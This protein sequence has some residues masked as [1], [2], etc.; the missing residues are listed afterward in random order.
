MTNMRLT[1][2]HET[3]FSIFPSLLLGVLSSA[4]RIGLRGLWASELVLL[5]LFAVAQEEEGD[6]VFIEIM[7]SFVTNYE[8]G[9]RL[10]YLKANIALQVNSEGEQV[11]RHHLPYLKNSLVLLLSSQAE[12]NLTSTMGREVLR[13]QALDE[14]KR[15][16]AQLE[17]GGD[18][19][20]S[21]LYFTDFIVQQ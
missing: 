4:R 1:T 15:A 7:P 10:K 14:V 3:L 12:E 2:S 9:A 6:R 18:M 11:V 16:M 19:L 21:E 13:Q 8:R 20:V 17:K 5:P